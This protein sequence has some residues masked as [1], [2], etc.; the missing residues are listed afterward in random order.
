MRE[1]MAGLFDEVRNNHAE[2]VDGKLQARATDQ[3][4]AIAR[5]EVDAAIAG[6]GDVNAAINSV[7]AQHTEAGLID[8]AKSDEALMALAAEYAS[9]GD[10]AGAEAILNADP[11]GK[12]SL[13]SRGSTALKAKEI[14][15]TG[16][17]NQASAARERKRCAPLRAGD[18]GSQWSLSPRTDRK[19]IDSWLGTG[20]I[21]ADAAEGRPHAERH[22]PAEAGHRCQLHRCA[23]GSQLQR[24]RADRIGTGGCPSGHRDCQLPDGTTKTVKANELKDTFIQQQVGQLI[25]TDGGGVAVA[26][27]HMASWGLSETFKPW[28]DSL[29]GG[30]LALT[31]ALTKPD[32]DGKVTIPPAT[33]A[34]YGLFKELCGHREAP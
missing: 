15:A 24:R 27:Q 8:E 2:Y 10:L 1:G 20:V 7:I 9:N 16:Q 34:A 19:Q 13:A 17:G 32:K 11:Y 33:Q 3:F 5:S 21:S 4:Y 29:S 26:A 23:R 22:G 12:G 6:G 14:L 28:Q 18:A 25:G 31:G 30:Y